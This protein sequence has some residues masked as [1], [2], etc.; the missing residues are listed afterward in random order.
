[1]RAYRAWTLV[2][3]RIVGPLEPAVFAGSLGFR[4]YRWAQPVAS[5]VLHRGS[6]FK[7]LAL[8]HRTQTTSKRLPA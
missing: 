2:V 1:M 7:A 6:K 5:P 4:Y 8:D 3:R